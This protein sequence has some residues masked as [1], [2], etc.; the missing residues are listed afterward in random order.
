MSWSDQGCGHRWGPVHILHSE[1]GAWGLHLSEIQRLAGQRGRYNYQQLHLSIS[2]YCLL[3]R[4]LSFLVASTWWSQSLGDQCVSKWGQV[5]PGTS[6]LGSIYR[7]KLYCFLYRVE[8]VKH[9]VKESNPILLTHLGTN[10][11]PR[12]DIMSW[13][14]WLLWSSS[15]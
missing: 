15:F 14:G 6:C 1:G 7:T 10:Q 4:F 9:W 8:H 12:W 11:F 3:F 13:W 2:K 5:W